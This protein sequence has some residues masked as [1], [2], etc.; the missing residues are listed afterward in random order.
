MKTGRVRGWLARTLGWVRQT[1]GLGKGKRPVEGSRSEVA[2][3][4]VAAASPA[5]DLPTDVAY[6]YCEACGHVVAG[7]PQ[8]PQTACAHPSGLR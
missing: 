8:G 5:P 4:P 6:S 1:L 3:A 7:G 2:E